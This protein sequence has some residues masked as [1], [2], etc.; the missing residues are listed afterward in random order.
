MDVT[1]NTFQV[2][3]MKVIIVWD[4][5]LVR[6]QPKVEKHFNHKPVSGDCDVGTLTKIWPFPKRTGKCTAGVL[7]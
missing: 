2:V 7:Q 4:G 3:G 5:S 6:Y 1:S